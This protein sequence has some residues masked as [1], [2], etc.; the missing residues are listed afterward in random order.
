MQLHQVIL[1]SSFSG[2]IYLI[3]AAQVWA[4]F[5]PFYRRSN[6]NLDEDL[7]AVV[8]WVFLLIGILLVSTWINV[9]FIAFGPTCFWV[10]LRFRTMLFSASKGPL[11]WLANSVTLKWPTLIF[12]CWTLGVTTLFWVG[13]ALLR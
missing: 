12:D 9:F 11:P 4:S 13:S 8:P 2:I 6:T 3:L 1:V 7:K 10:G 5:P